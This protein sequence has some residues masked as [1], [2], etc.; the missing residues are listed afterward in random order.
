MANITELRF[1]NDQI[2]DCVLA[3]P[4]ISREE[5]GRRFKVSAGWIGIVAG[6]DAFKERLEERKIEL[7]VKGEENE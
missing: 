2:I 1:M 7:R 4:T 5:L 6:S 3:N